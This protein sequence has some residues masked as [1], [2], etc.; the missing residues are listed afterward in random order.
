MQA[1]YGLA[2][3]FSRG[4]VAEETKAAVAL[5]KQL[6]VHAGDPAARFRAYQAQ[7]LASFSGGQIRAAGQTA[8]TYLAEARTAVIPYDIAFADILLGQVS[9][10][11]GA[12]AEARAHLAEA[13]DVY[14]PTW[15]TE[16]ASGG[17]LDLRPY[18]TVVLA[19]ACWQLGEVERAR[20]LI[21]QAKA[22]A[23]DYGNGLILAITYA[24]VPLLEVFRGDTEAA[25]RAAETLTNVVEKAGN[26][27]YSGSA[28]AFRSWARA[29][30]DP[31]VDLEEF[32]QVVLVELA[33]QSQV[34]MPL[35]KGLLAEFEA[36]EG[37]MDAALRGI[38]ESLALA[39][40]TDQR[41]TDSFLHRIRGDILLKADPDNS[42]PRRGRLP[43]SHRH[44]EGT[45]RAQLQ[46][47]GGAEARQALSIDRS[48]G[49]GARRPRAR[50]RGASRRRPKCPRS[51]RRRR[52]LSV[53][54]RERSR[55]QK[56]RAAE[57]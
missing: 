57:I 3:T 6:A 54:R 35:F 22:R 30:L 37:S 42:A 29:Q 52:C 18:A 7:F 24:F 45:R 56:G 43:N 4:P 15:H 55:I 14:D 26:P 50:P 39:E 27:L 33:E 17:V 44:R 40:Q 51:S 32:R 41:W 28:K 2:L 16:V 23:H 13:L 11:Q 1:D 19:L 48:P 31:A 53:W 49:R 46:P 9:M 25:L 34:G 36:D 8:E 21:E 20:E 10:H 47:A 12:F 38:D 5:A